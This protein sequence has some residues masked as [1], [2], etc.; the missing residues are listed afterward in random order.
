MSR[1]SLWKHWRSNV[2]G[3]VAHRRK[4]C[5]QLNI[6]ISHDFLCLGCVHE[7]FTQWTPCRVSALGDGDVHGTV[8]K[9]QQ[10]LVLLRGREGAACPQRLSMLGWAFPTVLLVKGNRLAGRFALSA[11]KRCI[12]SSMVH[13]L[14][15]K[16]LLQK[17]LQLRRVGIT[18]QNPYH[19]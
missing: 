8:R 5:S 10:E 2:V 9:L 6:C 7:V 15:P 13:G 14:T 18:E 11:C 19:S 4:R 3:L 16:I 17:D 1:F 12:G